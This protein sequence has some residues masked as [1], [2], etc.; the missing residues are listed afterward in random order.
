VMPCRS[1]LPCGLWF[2]T[3]NPLLVSPD[4]VWKEALSSRL[5]ILFKLTSLDTMSTL[6]DVIL[7]EDFSLY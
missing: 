3:L 1:G 4:D 2:K 7:Q 5:L 6:L